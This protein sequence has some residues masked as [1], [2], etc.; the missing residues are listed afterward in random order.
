MHESRLKGEGCLVHWWVHWSSASHPVYVKMTFIQFAL[1]QAWLSTAPHPSV[2]TKTLE[3]CLER[4]T[5]HLDL[6]RGSGEIA[7]NRS[8][9]D[10]VKRLITRSRKKRKLISELPKICKQKQ[11]SDI[12]I[13]RMPVTL[14]DQNSV[15]NVSSLILLQTSSA[16]AQFRLHTV[17]SVQLI[18]CL[19]TLCWFVKV[20]V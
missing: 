7:T 8:A 5:S 12:N 14:S 9:G 2:H 11:L 13:D 3:L 20:L 10:Y 16:G 17:H 6:W 18:M 4:S 15:V 1:H 19:T